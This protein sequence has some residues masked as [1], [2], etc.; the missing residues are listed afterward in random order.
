MPRH[1]R[2]NNQDLPRQ[3]ARA[4][5]SVV[6]KNSGVSAKPVL[7]S[8]DN[9]GFYYAVIDDP[10]QVRLFKKY[11]VEQKIPYMDRDSTLP[12]EGKVVPKAKPRP[13]EPKPK[14]IVT[15]V[16]EGLTELGK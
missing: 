9:D 1:I 3:T 15:E 5:L 7:T 8:P 10:K 13:E 11:L 4:A 16:V 2:I 12:G 14:D 6:R